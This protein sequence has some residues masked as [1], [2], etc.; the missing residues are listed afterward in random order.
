MIKHIRQRVSYKEN[1]LK[2]TLFADTNARRSC[3]YQIDPTCQ[4][5]HEFLESSNY[6]KCGLETKKQDN[7]TEKSRP[8]Q[9]SICQFTAF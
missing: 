7:S 8:S 5:P 4:F 1:T 3:V 9:E 6:K 2:N